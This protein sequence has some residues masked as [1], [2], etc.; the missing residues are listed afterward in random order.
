MRETLF[1]LEIS[2]VEI[3]NRDFLTINR[4]EIG[5]T[6]ILV[7]AISGGTRLLDNIWL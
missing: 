7:E 4:V 2:Y 5:N 1:P 3:V 6:I